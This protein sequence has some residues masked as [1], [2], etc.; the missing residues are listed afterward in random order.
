[1]TSRSGFVC[2]VSSAATAAKEGEDAAGVR[3]SGGETRDPGTD[4]GAALARSLEAVNG[5]TEGTELTASV[6]FG[7]FA[8]EVA[9]LLGDGG[10]AEN[11]LGSPI[12]VVDDGS[13]MATL[14]LAEA[15]ADLG[16]RTNRCLLAEEGNGSDSAQ[17]LPGAQSTR[18]CASN[19]CFC[20]DCVLARG[21]RHGFDGVNGER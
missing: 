5:S 2:L 12:L 9:A 6:G 16:A 8:R 19:R 18:R 10:G 20:V 4:V 21:K 13:A 7:A 3:D 1:M 17:S 14:P 11:S 15:N